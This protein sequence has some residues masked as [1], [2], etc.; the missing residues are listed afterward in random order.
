MVIAASTISK[1]IGNAGQT[2]VSWHWTVLGLPVVLTFISLVNFLQIGI[3]GRSFPAIARLEWWSRL[4]AWLN[5]GQ[6]C[7]AGCCG[8]GAGPA[9]MPGTELAVE[10]GLLLVAGK[11]ALA[12]GSITWI[13]STGS[14]ACAV[15]RSG[16]RCRSPHLLKQ[17]L[18][19]RVFVRTAPF[20]FIGGLFVLISLDRHVL[21]GLRCSAA[22]SWSRSSH[23]GRRNGAS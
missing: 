22:F 2:L 3:L 8:A 7:M 9:R 15:C 17:P 23:L 13:V 4:G 12:G 14:S 20:V 21:A 16:I 19:R 5:L 10:W 11:I 18:W 1:L 6:P